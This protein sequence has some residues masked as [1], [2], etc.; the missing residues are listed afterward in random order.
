MIAGANN[1]MVGIISYI[2]K[3]VDLCE[4]TRCA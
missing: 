3:T 2:E 4:N 1:I